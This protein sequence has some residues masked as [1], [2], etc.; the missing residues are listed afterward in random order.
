MV[1]DSTTLIGNQKLPTQLIKKVQ[2]HKDNS[3]THYWALI[4][5][6]EGRA[7]PKN[8]WMMH[9]SRFPLLRPI[10]LSIFALV[11]GSGASERNFSTMKSIHTLS[12][13]CLGVEKV[14]KLTYIKTN[15]RMVDKLE[16]GSGII[17]WWRYDDEVVF[18]ESA[19]TR[20]AATLAARES[21]RFNDNESSGHSGSDDE[22]SSSS[23]DSG[24]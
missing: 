14:E 4:K 7:K 21:D 24:G 6:G 2:R 10:A 1:P 18:V 12:R 22:G 15:G 16:L 5:V 9:G 23:S 13:N 8:Y 3:D 17:S 20:A 19:A 11:G